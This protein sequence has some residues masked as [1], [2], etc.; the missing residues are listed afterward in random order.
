MFSEILLQYTAHV[1]QNTMWKNFGSVIY[2]MKGYCC[3]TTNVNYIFCYVFI[4]T[5]SHK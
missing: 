2:E 3:L 1:K 5:V 4:Q